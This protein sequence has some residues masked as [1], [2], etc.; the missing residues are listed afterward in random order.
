M[1][2]GVFGCQ[3]LSKSYYIIPWQQARLE[4]TKQRENWIEKIR[5]FIFHF[6]RRKLL[7]VLFLDPFLIQDIYYPFK[8]TPKISFFTSLRFRFCFHE[9]GFSLSNIKTNCQLSFAL[10]V[11]KDATSGSS[12]CV[13]RSGG[14]SD[15]LCIKIGCINPNGAKNREGSSNLAGSSLVFLSDV[16]FDSDWLTKLRVFRAQLWLA[17]DNF[18][19][20]GE[21]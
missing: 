21:I 14:R 18:P 19:V 6:H 17:A 10:S 16:I 11:L 7:N 1:E 15:T 4:Q 2:N 12:I 20:L 3:K 13:S 8:C 5:L 9:L